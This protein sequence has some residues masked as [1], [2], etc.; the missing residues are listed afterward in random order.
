MHPL[1]ELRKKAL[2]RGVD[3]APLL[4]AAG[5][6]TPLAAMGMAGDDQVYGAVLQKAGHILRVMTEQSVIPLGLSM[7]SIL[8]HDPD[9]SLDL[10]KL[11][12]ELNQIPNA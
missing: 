9:E 4:S 7:K 1:G 5:I 6:V 12:H 10:K 8:N 2:P 11:N 3:S